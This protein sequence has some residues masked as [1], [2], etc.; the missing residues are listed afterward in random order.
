MAWY[1]GPKPEVGSLVIEPDGRHVGRVAAVRFA[2]GTAPPLVHCYVVR[3]LDTGWT[4]ELQ[5]DQIELA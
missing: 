3:W 4:S 5:P 2:S 1:T